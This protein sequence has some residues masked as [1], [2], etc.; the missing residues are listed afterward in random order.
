MTRSSARKSRW[1][2]TSSALGVAAGLVA[3]AAL[4]E[5]PNNNLN[6]NT[7]PTLA[8]PNA[9][10]GIGI[11]YSDFGALGG[12]VCT[13]TLINPRTIIF[14][15]HCVNTQGQATYGR[16]SGGTPIAVGFKGDARAGLINWLGTGRSSVADQTYNLSHVFYDQRSLLEPAGNFYEA[17]VA[18]GVLDTAARGVPTWAMLFSPLTGTENLHV[19]IGGYGRSGTGTT[20]QSA[21]V[22]FRRRAGENMIGALA[23]IDDVN[24][25]LFG[26]GSQRGLGQNLYLVDFDDPA[27]ANQFDFNIFGNDVALP[28]EGITAQGDSG[29]ALILDRAFSQP[30]I[31]G[32]LSLGTRYFGAQPQA[33]YG[34]TAGYQPLYLFW[35][36]IV[37]NNP[38]K[39]VQAKAGDG[40]WFDAT[41]W[42]QMMDPNYKVVSGGQLTTG[43]PGT[44]AA[45][46]GGQGGEF[47]AV[48]FNADCESAKNLADYNNS[49]GGTETA[50]A[51]AAGGSSSESNVGHVTRDDLTA[52]LTTGT[53]G[54]ADGDLAAPAALVQAPGATAPFEFVAGGPGS[55]NFVPNNVA[56]VPG[57]TRPAYYD[58]SLTTA[59]R[60]TLN[61]AATVDRLTIGTSGAILD[62]T[63]TG[64]LTN[65][66]DTTVTAGQLNVDGRLNT[67]EMLLMGGMLSGKGVIDPTVL[68]S[69]LGTIAPG[70][71]NAVGD[72]TI[73]GDLVLTSGSRL[74]ID[75]NGAQ[76]DRLIVRAD[77]AQGTRGQASIGGFLGVNPLGPVQFGQ[78]YTVLTA[79]G[80][81]SGRFTSATDLPGVLFPTLG[82]TANSVLLTIDA[83][84][85]S[86]VID[87]NSPS[88]QAVGAL[89][90]RA[91]PGSYAALSS[92]YGTVDVLEGPVLGAALESLA[93]YS[94]RSAVKLGAVQTETLQSAIG[95]R[96]ALRRTGATGGL[97]LIG[98]GVEVAALSDDLAPIAAAAM[99]AAQDEGSA[100]NRWSNGWKEGVSAFLTAGATDGKARNLRGSVIGSGE[101]QQ[102]SWYFAG[103][104]ERTVD[105]LTLGG[106]LGYSKGKAEYAGALSRADTKQIQASAYASLDIADRGFL[107]GHLGYGWLDIETRR[108]TAVGGGLR[109]DGDTEGD[110]FFGGVEI[111]D[112]VDT[113]GVTVTPSFGVNAYRVKVDG[114]AETG[115][116]AALR[117]DEQTSTSVQGFLGLRVSGATKVGGFSVKPALSVRAVTDFTNSRDDVRAVFAAAGGTPAT[118]LGASRDTTWGE[119][120]GGVTIGD[121]R[122][123]VSLE[124]SSMIERQDID[125]QSYRAT[126]AFKF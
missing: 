9:V 69:I 105:D 98:R 43:L 115:S 121:E 56:G 26:D 114:Y 66:I 27:R 118:F 72:L 16:A 65:L 122:T 74:I 103:G 10:N 8:A 14:A 107:G 45:G 19:T 70:G 123:T 24:L 89:L 90:D 40:D 39:Y 29:G 7:A 55:T 22:D 75:V 106:A 76:A 49:Q 32:V 117:V 53:A 6:R 77:A 1:L 13:G 60:T 124:A 15:A 5:V 80:G 73:L 2:S 126:V 37:A 31:A 96:I 71:Q 102:D 84:S 11:I 28:G 95:D 113:R 62:V 3:G 93:P 17:D 33:S 4:A 120:S 20:G 104:V 110:V 100:R 18:M 99:A 50:A 94:S 59:G 125:Y 68:T 92:V 97:A 34:T 119:I 23:S 101:D 12:G 36:Y 112:R 109:A 41:R 58:V 52:D 79:E 47:G 67:F 63:S 78:A 48:C 64:T 25:F 61:R 86:T 21:G 88:Q 91:R 51:P 46:V 87:A 82:Y 57:G 30:V 54:T 116:A 111:G 83:A 35:D 81:I 108:N 38:Y 44:P 42:T 85:F